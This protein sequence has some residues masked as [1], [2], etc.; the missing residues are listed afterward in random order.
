[1]RSLAA[2]NDFRRTLSATA[3]LAIIA[4][5]TSVALTALPQSAD[6][7]VRRPLPRRVTL[8]VPKAARPLQILISLRKQRLRI[9]DG[10]REVTSSRISSGRAG[11]DTPS[12]VFTILEKNRHHVSNI[13]DAEMP[14][15]Q[16]LTWSGIAMHAGVVPG[17][18]A[19]HG[20]IRL[21][22]QFARNFFETTRMGGRVVVTQDETHPVSFSHLAL[23]RPLPAEVPEDRLQ[24][25]G[26]LTASADKPAETKVAAAG[27]ARYADGGELPSL[28][29]ATAV[30][31]AEAMSASIDEYS[32]VKPRSRAEAVRMLEAR[33]A[34]LQ[35]GLTTAETEKLAATE[36]A[37]A[38]VRAAD[39]ADAKYRAARAP[40]EPVLRRAEAAS[41]AKADAIRAFHAALRAPKRVVNDK[42]RDDLAERELALED[43]ILDASIEADQARVASAEADLL[44]A[45]LKSQASAAE[46]KKAQAI[47]HV[48]GK[49]QALRTAQTSLIE[50]R[51]DLT[52]RYRPLS[53][54]ISLKSQR[55]FVR[56]GNDPIFEGQVRARGPLPPVGTQVLTALDYDSS[57]D[58]FQ[59]SLVSAQAPRAFSAPE[60]RD[61]KTSRRNQVDAQ[62]SLSSTAALSEVLDLIE[63]PDEIRDMVAERAVA[64][65]ALIISDR[66]LS[67]ETGKGTEFV[68]LTR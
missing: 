67:S 65:F 23:F 38:A 24:N 3:V 16:R 46:A 40:V 44:L 66:D 27:D 43:R 48:K 37:K 64:G 29:S 31:A 11:F 61:R 21:P 55:I 62:P 56:Q 68:V 30:N 10:S 41:A 35:T 25:P 1:M 34:K 9:F 57:G 26:D 28:L 39:D 4:L 63:I 54:F 53:V 19:S 20:C 22:Y 45:D 6:A 7:E 33:I 36:T 13:Y 17:Y 8:E 12:G 58:A 60:P 42:A 14:F 15:M 59:W 49:V 47:E 2:S 52:E 18:R 51:R 5:A 32:T 50:A